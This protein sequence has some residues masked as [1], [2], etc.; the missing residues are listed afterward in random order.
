MQTYAK[1]GKKTVSLCANNFNT[2]KLDESIMKKASYFL[3]CSIIL[4]AFTNC[5]REAQ[6]E[7]PSQ[8]A[9]SVFEAITTAD[10]ATLRNKI[11]INDQI[12]RDVFNDYFKIAAASKQYIEATAHYKPVYNVVSETIDGEN[13]EVILTTKNISGQ[14]V[15]LT[16]KLLLDEDG[17]WKV[18]GD[19]GVWH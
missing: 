15:R 8:V 11:H 2:H 16:V 13:A 7:S 10:T 12:Q 19:H 9:L 5:H 1:N 18:D 14:N 3:L 17:Y 6:G 4:A